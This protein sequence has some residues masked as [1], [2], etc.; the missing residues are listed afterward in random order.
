[1]TRTLTIVV[2]AYNAGEALVP[3]VRLVAEMVATLVPEGSGETTVVVVDDGSTD[4]SVTALRSAVAAEPA[5]YVGVEVV[6]HHERHG[7]GA[8]LRTGFGARP[9]SW[10]G[11]CDGDGDIDPTV[12]LRL[13][14]EAGLPGVGGG[15][16]SSPAPG[17]DAVCAV[18]TASD[19]PYLRL[20][21]SELFK[22]FRRAVLP[23][24]LRD[25]QTGAKLFAGEPLA[26]VLPGLREDG[27][28]FDLEALAALRAVGHGRFVAVP[29]R[30]HR[31]SSSSVTARSV[32]QLAWATIRV[33]AR[34]RGAALRSGR[35][36]AVRSRGRTP[37]M[38]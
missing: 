7:K 23:L 4:G 30:A 32:V 1:M 31:V 21:G 29:V 3:T 10:V 24:G 5:A 35:R 37:G 12:L 13:G 36:A 20:V 17:P 6:E 28:A 27:F 8:A 38:G 33:A 22:V 34:Y 15:E 9:A 16:G 14:A 18:K 2:P 26:A 25:S 19:L 11:F